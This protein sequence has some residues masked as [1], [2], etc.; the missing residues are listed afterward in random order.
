MA[1]GKIDG[2][3]ET[4]R[5]APDGRIKVVRMF[6]RRGVVWSD[7]ILVDRKTLVEKLNA[8]RKI[9]T[10]S[11]RQYLGSMFDTG[12]RVSLQNGHIISDKQTPDRDCLGDV[13]VF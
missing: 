11:R 5:Y 3:I 12:A 4:V 10:G 2:V 7:H 1:R 8:G 9:V 13:G 6:E